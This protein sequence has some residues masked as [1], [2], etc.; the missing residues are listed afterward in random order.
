MESSVLF[1]II[2]NLSLIW[3]F[4]LSTRSADVTIYFV[5]CLEFF[6]EGG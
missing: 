5:A 1:G 4:F 3:I 2:W 6:L